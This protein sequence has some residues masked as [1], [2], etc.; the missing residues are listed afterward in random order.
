MNLD[1]LLTRRE[2]ADELTISVRTLESMAV[3]GD[4]PTMTK[5]GRLCRYRL[6]H[7]REYIESRARRHTHDTPSGEVK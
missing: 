3:R 7:I 1:P 6:S 5:I 2:A 4:G